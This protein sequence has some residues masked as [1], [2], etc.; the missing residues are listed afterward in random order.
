MV[1]L[2]KTYECIYIGGCLIRVDG[3]CEEW[4]IR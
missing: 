4:V 2:I 1:L 3:C